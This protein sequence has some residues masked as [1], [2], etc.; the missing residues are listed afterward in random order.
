MNH[1]G[2]MEELEEVERMPRMVTAEL[3][4]ARRNLA[5]KSPA[6][7]NRWRGDN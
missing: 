4:G 2:Q 6:I 5:M 1:H 7:C 3:A